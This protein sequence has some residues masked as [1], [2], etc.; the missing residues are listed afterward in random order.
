MLDF[1]IARV[2]HEDDG[3]FEEILSEKTIAASPSGV[4]LQCNLY[5]PHFAIAN[6]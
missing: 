3:Y 1:F 2:S 4:V 5:N 6:N